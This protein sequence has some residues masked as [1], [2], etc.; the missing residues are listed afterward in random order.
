MVGTSL[1]TAWD[2]PSNDRITENNFEVD[3]SICQKWNTFSGNEGDSH[4][5][6]RVKLFSID[7]DGTEHERDRIGFPDAFFDFIR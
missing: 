4:P 2:S 7:S 5:A 6:S 1:L 3:G